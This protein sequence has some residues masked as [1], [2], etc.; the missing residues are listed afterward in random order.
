MLDSLQPALIDLA[1][2][3][4][5]IIVVGFVIRRITGGNN[6]GSL[7]GKWPFIA[8]MV[9]AGIAAGLVI[10]IG[11]LRLT[12]PDVDDIIARD[13]VLPTILEAFPDQ[14][15]G[16]RDRLEHAAVRGDAA[17][18][19]EVAAIGRDIGATLLPRT[20]G[21]AS[22]EAVLGF[23]DAFVVSAEEASAQ[24][25]AACLSYITGGAAGG[26]MPSFSPAVRDATS[27]AVMRVI[28]EGA[29]GKPKR[30]LGDADFSMLI[31]VA[32]DEAYDLAADREL[33]FDAY[34]DLA[35]VADEETRM[36]VCWT[37]LYLHRAIQEM[38]MAQGASLY[39]ALMAAQ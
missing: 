37:A 22:D 25:G 12:A 23:V 5:I 33:D 31:D 7:K 27:T 3:L 35:A 34:A 18:G 13:S 6:P 4:V 1:P 26:P 11:I 28:V 24:G 9:V 19:R 15:P 38:P 17:I 21:S 29:A 2:T 10:Q 32:V 30:A 14:E 8:G 20:I 16:I 36:R 39:R